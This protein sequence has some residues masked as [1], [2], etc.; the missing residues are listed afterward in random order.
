M[1]EAALQ[2]KMEAKGQPADH[3]PADGQPAGQPAH[4]LIAAAA[5]WPR[6]FMCLECRLIADARERAFFDYEWDSLEDVASD[7]EEAFQ[8]W[9]R[10]QEEKIEQRKARWRQAL[11]QARAGGKGCTHG[12]NHGPYGYGGKGK[13]NKDKDKSNKGK[14]KSNKDKSNKDN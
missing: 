11:A 12:K 8:E 14:D 7:D 3:Q 10:V 4:D 9:K 5:Q 6:E 13:S 2:F 1:S